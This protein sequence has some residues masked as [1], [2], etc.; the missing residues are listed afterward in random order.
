MKALEED[1]DVQVTL[2]ESS[3]DQGMFV[4]DT[5]AFHKLNCETIFLR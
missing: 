4:V 2:A 1:P 3:P 5:P